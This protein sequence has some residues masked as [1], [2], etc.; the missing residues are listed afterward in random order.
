MKA[1]KGNKVYTITE[2]EKQR[3]QTEGYDIQDD[4][5]ATIAY[6]KGKTVSYE[7]HLSVKKERDELKQRVEELQ[8]QLE[9]TPGEPESAN[10]E[11]AGKSS[12][13]KA[14]E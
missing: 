11:K 8:K 3:Y 6:G 12:S 1:V 14:G 13:K 9:G 4:A 2:S 10:A 5:G 7:E